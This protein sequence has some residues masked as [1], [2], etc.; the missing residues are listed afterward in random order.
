MHK[1][2]FLWGSWVNFING[3]VLFILK[4][5]GSANLLID[6]HDLN[7]EPWLWRHRLFKVCDKSNTKKLVKLAYFHRALIGFHLLI[8][9]LIE[10]GKCNTYFISL[11]SLIIKNNM[12]SWFILLIN[13]DFV[14]CKSSPGPL[15]LFCFNMILRV[16]IHWQLSLYHK[17][18]SRLNMNIKPWAWRLNLWFAF[19][20]WC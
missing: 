7:W 17:H 6:I 16:F 9:P 15:R 12:L 18:V 13:M 3:K 20:S 5:L 2:Y 1:W 19:N 11:F 14:S 4:D 10:F 8:G